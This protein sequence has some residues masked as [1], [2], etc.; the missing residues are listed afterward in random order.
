MDAKVE[1]PQAGDV[2]KATGVAIPASKPA[3]V[4]MSALDVLIGSANL[5]PVGRRQ[6]PLPQPYA[7]VEDV[8][9]ERVHEL[10][11]GARNVL[12]KHGW[13]HGWGTEQ[14]GTCIEGGIGIA[15]GLQWYEHACVMDSVEG[16]ACSELL[17]K[18]VGGAAH[19]GHVAAS[20]VISWN[21]SSTQEAVFAALDLAI[22]ATAP[23]LPVDPF[24][25]DLPTHDHR[26]DQGDDISLS[27]PHVPLDGCEAEAGA[28]T[29][30]MGVAVL[31]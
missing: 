27:T 6:Y 15:L 9:V 18:T 24:P 26:K 5:T 3:T 25:H 12:N 20:A 31:A 13:G 7:K 29:A 1:V 17:L 11:V 21:D 10:L 2:A 19:R 28:G 30:G 16:H 8:P 23:Q 22:R 14:S 4:S